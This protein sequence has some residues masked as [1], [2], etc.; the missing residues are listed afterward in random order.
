MEHCP[1]CGAVEGEGLKP[2]E[3]VDQ[4]GR[5]WSFCYSGLDHGTTVVNGEVVNIPN[6]PFVFT[7]DVNNYAYSN[8]QKK[9]RFIDPTVFLFQVAI[10]GRTMKLSTIPWSDVTT[11]SPV[12]GYSKEDN[13]DYEAV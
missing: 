9:S 4:N 6:D 2:W 7:Y 11:G 1:L 5:D 3:L 10:H 8:G 12:G 13:H